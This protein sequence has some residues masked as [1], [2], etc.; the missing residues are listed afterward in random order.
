MH[1]TAA[2]ECP[3][4]LVAA[5]HVG[6]GW[7]PRTG[8][9]RLTQ[10]PRWAGKHGHRITPIPRVTRA[11]IDAGWGR[12]AS[13]AAKAPLPAPVAGRVAERPNHLGD[14][15]MPRAGVAISRFGASCGGR[16]PL[17]SRIPNIIW[18]NTCC[19][20]PNRSLICP[21]NRDET[22]RH[23]HGKAQKTQSQQVLGH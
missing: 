12:R 13:D 23:R 6:G 10:G 4:A 7:I 17:R 11:R 1:R 16:P 21:H 19:G 18:E 15:Q 22:P 14:S 5:A 8:R 20:P 2:I 9:W 3:Q